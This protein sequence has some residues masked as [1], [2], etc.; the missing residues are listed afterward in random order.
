MDGKRC[1]S[2]G[3]LRRGR[4]S[5]EEAGK[6]AHGELACAIRLLRGRD[7]RNAAKAC[8]PAIQELVDRRG[9]TRDLVAHLTK[10]GSPAATRMAAFAG[11]PEG[12][13]AVTAAA[14][15]SN[16]SCYRRSTG[17]ISK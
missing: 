3:Y 4:P 1:S 2:A 7:I 9:A 14:E 12:S 15:Q 11:Y 5:I 17:A 10:P 13:S 16:L 6:A 8:G